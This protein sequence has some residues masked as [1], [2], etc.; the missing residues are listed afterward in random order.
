M[1]SRRRDDGAAAFR[2]TERCGGWQRVSALAMVVL[3]RPAMVVLSRP[4]A[5]VPLVFNNK[6]K[7]SQV[8]ATRAGEPMR[9]DF[10]PW[11]DPSARPLVRFA[12]VTKRFAGVTAVDRLSLD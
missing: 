8:A 10:A 11:A 3:S 6:N 2:D 1:A 12:A 4:I 7:Q 9:R 5:C